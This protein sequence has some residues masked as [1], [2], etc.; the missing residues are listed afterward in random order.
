[1]EF[2]ALSSMEEINL[3]TYETREMPYVSVVANVERRWH[4]SFVIENKVFLH[5]G[6]NNGGPLSDMISFNMENSKWEQVAVENAPSARRWHTV[7]P[8]GNMKFLLYGGYYGDHSKL[9][10]DM[11][12]LDIVKGSWTPLPAKGDI[13][14]PRRNHTITQISDKSFLLIGGHELHG[15]CHDAYV[16]HSDEMSWKKVKNVGELYYATRSSHKTVKVGEHG[17]V[18][19]GGYKQN[20]ID[21]VYYLDTRMLQL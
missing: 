2:S 11:H 20:Y 10:G 1:M 12:V 19:V 6:W 14:S 8:I 4:C 15:T 9:L 13:P 16:F 18:I 5:G 3:D 7:T 21:P 17:V